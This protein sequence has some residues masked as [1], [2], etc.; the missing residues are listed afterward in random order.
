MQRRPC[1]PLG[2]CNLSSINLSEFVR[3]PFTEKAKFEYEQFGEMVRQGVIFLNEVLDE[4][5]KLHPLKQ[6]REMAR[7]LRQI[8]LGIMGVADMFI[9][10]GIKYGS[11]ESI[12][13]IHKIGKVLIN[14][15]LKQSAL[16]AK[17]HGPFPKYK[18]EACIKITLLIS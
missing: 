4:N 1:Q 7:E 10:M 6:Q 3:N 5:M 9:K 16:L 12:D 18:E 8:G 2:S 15:A 17:E 14:E 11:Q 13:L